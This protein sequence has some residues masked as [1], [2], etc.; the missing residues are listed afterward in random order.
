M[1]SAIPSITFNVLVSLIFILFISTHSKLTA[2]TLFINEFM[3]SNVTS[4]PEIV[5]F[6]DYSDW[7]EIYNDSTS[8]INIGGYYL[9]DDLDN[10]TKWQIPS[11]TSIPAK[12]FLIFW[13]DGYDT[14]SGNGIK[15]H[16]LNFKLSKSGEE[17]GL[18]SP[19]EVLI[20]SV[21]YAVQVSDVSFG[22]KPDG[23]SEWN[24]FGEATQSR[25]NITE[26]I[27]TT[28]VTES[29]EFAL[30]SGFYSGQ[31]L[32][33]ISTTVGTAIITYTKDGS[34]PTSSSQ[35]YT[36]PIGISDNTVLRARTFKGGK[37]PSKI[38][39]SSYFI[40]QEQTLPILSLTVFPET[41]FNSE[42]GI[43]DNQIKSREVPVNVQYFER[44]GELGF[45]LNA[46]IR[47]TGQA[48]FQYPQKPLT[49]EADDKFGAESIEY[50][51]FSDRQ[52][53][54]YTSIYLRNSG[55][56][57]N[58]HT[59]FRDALQH[60]IVINQMDIDCQAYQ[61]AATFI[62]G[63]YWGIYNVREKLDNNYLFA[64]HGINTDNID[65]L[66]YEFSPQP[67]VIEGSTDYYFALQNF[68]ADNS[69]NIVENWEYVKTQIDINEIL[70]YLI[71]EIY[72]DNYNWPN[73]N[74]RWWKENSDNGKWRYVFLDSDYGFGAPSWNS[75]YSNNTLQF[76]YSQPSYSTFVFRKLLE[77]KEFK[78]E[79][80]QRFATYLNTIFLKERVVEIVDSLQNQIST[81]MIK[82]IDRWDDDPFPIYGYPPIPDIS[83]WNMEVGIM[84]EFAEQR[85]EFMKEHLID[86]F[87]IS[88]VES[89]KYNLND[90]NRGSILLGGIKVENGFTGDYFRYVPLKIEAIPSVGYK[91]V[92]W[93]GVPD[94]LSRSTYFTPLRSD[95]IFQITAIFEEDN[96]NIIPSIIA[97][98][99]NLT[100]SG[101]PYYA[102]GDILVNL[103][104]NLSIDSGVEILMPKDADLIING[105]LEMNGTENQPII[106]R[107]N[108]I[109][110][111]D[112]WGCIYIHNAPGQSVINNVQLIGATQDKE[113][114]NKIGA[115]SGYNSDLIIEN[116]TILDAPFPIFIQ[117]G[118]AII[119]NCKLHTEKTSDLI[120]I[121]Y[122]ES[123]LVEN[124]DL[125]GNN[126]VDTDAIDYDQ[127]S[128]GTIRG[129]KIYNFYGFNS[130]GIDLGEG[131]KDILIEENLILNCNDKGI[132]VGQASTTNIKNN[133]I[134]NCAQGVGV[135]DDSSYAFIDVNTFYNCDYGVA[136]FEKNLGSGGGNADIVN[137]IFSKSAL[138]PIF[139]DN[140]SILNVSYSL[141]DTK[142]LDGI[143]NLNADPLF[144][145]NFILSSL[146][147]AINAGNPQSELDPDG[148]R[149]DLGA[150]YFSGDEEPMI[151][152]E[153]HYNPEN[154]ENYEFIELYNTGSK[155][156][157]LSGYKIS[158]AINF[159]FP[160][161]SS[162]KSNEFIILA[163][164]NKLYDNLDVQVF[165]WGDQSLPNTWANVTVLN[166]LGKE[167]DFVSYSNK[168]DWPTVADGG[169]NS[170]ELRNP[171]EENLVTKHWK[172]SSSSGGSPGKA[173]KLVLSNNLF[174]NEFQ[175]DNKNTIKDEYGEY[176]D[177]IEIFN[178]SD[179]TIDLGHLYITDN[180]TNLTKHQIVFTNDETNTLAPKERLILWADGNTD[181][182]V[183]HLNF[184]LDVG[185]E[186][187][188]LVYIFENDTTII[189]S[190][191]FSN[192]ETD[193]SYARLNDGDNDWRVIKVPTPGVMNSN[194]GLFNSGILLVNGFRLTIDDAIDSYENRVFWGSYNISFWDLLSEPSNG[195]PLSLPQPIG[196]GAIP[197]DT[198]TN[199]STII[200]TGENSASE[201]NF[202]N[203]S[204]ALEY[205]KM[206]G[207]L[208][209]LFKNGRGYIDG[210]MLER[211]GIT[212]AEPENAKIANCA[213]VYEGLDSISIK[214][215]QYSNSVFNPILTN[216]NSS[217]LF[218]E[219]LTYGKPLGIGVWNKPTYGGWYKEGGSQIL[220][221]S[222]R[223]YRY[224]NEELKNNMEFMLENFME[225]PRIISDDKS[226]N[227]LVI[228]E[229]K[230][231]QNYPNPF[232]PSTLIKYD[233][234]K[235]SKVDLKIY[236]ILGQEVI[237]LV[238]K[239]E[240]KGRKTVL[241]NG[242]DNFN[243]K[244]SSGIYFYRIS[245]G[246]WNDIKKMILMK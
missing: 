185:G 226:I 180:Y 139:V 148:T 154:G 14:P 138:A 81:E 36:T 99:T 152:N 222:G 219:T 147:S 93:T 28:E 37:L 217:L 21:V 155:S 171:S 73:T 55:T 113:D 178:A 203:N 197:L 61:P 62:N 89:I 229:Y 88:G 170:L 54:S 210:E 193:F 192:Q 224:D 187:I 135:K 182:G 165:S 98:N 118:N 79:F 83:T 67:V 85:P 159:I 87:N 221:L 174:I 198:L 70:N 201:M 48:S 206:G 131:S 173:N 158:E 239:Y 227:N 47:L 77:N 16:H 238:N 204:P 52:F 114:P 32:V 164:D 107:P 241:W 2:Q 56:Q 133:I 44:G 184:K 46:G 69:M 92:K 33:S 59:L 190:I 125:R 199:Y 120:N 143:E 176:D 207:N 132:S 116:T 153:I 146:S 105:I 233:L 242:R 200:W 112:K 108:L 212:W 175:A 27:T 141:S 90:P 38:V 189:D 172:A 234:V 57:D 126:N 7:I 134:V 142:E 94:S 166:N 96:V 246:D 102:K 31:Q 231:N 161:G 195:Y 86:F 157:D 209:L 149:T 8:S 97:Q 228:T 213:S 63:Q 53:E 121:K 64:H 50:P 243:N 39:T 156:I 65:Y 9:T 177:W 25:R 194:P 127:I 145:N 60:S 71:T 18:F 80:I 129:N 49:I 75:H 58:R 15:Y 160:I 163:K 119:R 240:D 95:S 72:C 24:Y 106:I 214:E 179:N 244:V 237:T 216:N 74:S 167:I 5:D 144:A 22:R 43:Y 41:F 225:E 230:L 40:D 23:G 232:N 236:D 17:I 186:E 51:V 11:G 100:I 91:F 110:G 12:G 66:E 211:L 122:A 6:D 162:I 20:D 196:R 84:R 104:A 13:A 103:G 136:S 223:A 188:A 109:S 1:K 220:F 29:P 205:V 82:H 183:N 191:S 151:I 140:L 4:N 208:I 137:S 76:L 10:S 78:N 34:R 123:A 101:S 35:Q 19:E 218:T 115:I 117:Y 235:K 128:N 3:A 130:D 42:I 45:E 168:F 202:W 169:G 245:A 30:A 215:N 68:L 181:Q 111:F 150:N 26:G 124:C